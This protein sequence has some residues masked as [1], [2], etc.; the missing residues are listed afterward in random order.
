[1]TKFT[2]VIPLYNKEQHI[3]R[4]LRSVTAQTFTD[5]EVVVVDD[6]STDRGAQVVKAFEDARIRLIRQANAGVS[7]ARNRG[8]ADA[9]GELVAFLDADDEWSPSHLD[10]LARLREK[11]P[12]AGLYSMAYRTCFHTGMMRISRIEK[13]PPPPW[14]G[15]I[16]DYFKTAAYR[17][18]PV[19][20]SVACIPRILFKELGGFLVGERLGEDLDMWGRVAL[21]YPVAFSWQVGGT[22]YRNAVNRA[23]D[24]YLMERELPFI[25]TAQDALGK[26]R[27]SEHLAVSLGEYILK[28]RL[29]MVRTHI[30]S[31]N[32]SAARK[33][34][35]ECK[36]MTPMLV[37][38]KLVYSLL[39]VLPGGA[40]RALILYKR[41]IHLKRG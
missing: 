9:K 40:G 11:F 12:Q 23:S 19:N 29:D 18:S 41:L 38:R 17:D 31:A 33:I 26:G 32:P 6:G 20:A 30:L 34:L 16:P 13:L 2:V 36:P 21:K 22:N 8:I 7:A 5:F 4:A 24:N 14:E 25:R 39:A 1:M 15:I 28:L 10:V 3:E 37:A 35:V 27:V